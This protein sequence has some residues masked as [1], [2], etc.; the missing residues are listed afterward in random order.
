MTLTVKK[1]KTYQKLIFPKV[2][3]PLHIPRHKPQN[4]RRATR[5]SAFV[6]FIFV[7]VVASTP[8][9]RAEIRKKITA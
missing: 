2:T 8:S 5:V 4:D 1:K 7:L 9:T 6:L 3:P